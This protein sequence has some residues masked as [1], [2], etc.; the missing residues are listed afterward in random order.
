M[1]HGF[2]RILSAMLESFYIVMK[3]FDLTS[4]LSLSAKYEHTSERLHED[5]MNN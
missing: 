4:S 5:E 3:C 1:G 2:R